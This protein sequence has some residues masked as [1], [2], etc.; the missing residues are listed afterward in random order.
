MIKLSKEI[1]EFLKESNHIEKEYSN[2]A[3][4]DSKKAWKFAYDNKNKI[5]LD[6]ILEIHR[7]LMERIRSDIAGKLRTCDVMI[8][9]KRKRFVSN[10]IMEVELKD[11]LNNISIPRF[12]PNKE[13]EFAKHCHVMFEEIH[14]FE[15]GN[16]RTGRI[17]Y[18]IQRLNLGLPIHTIHV[19]EEQMEY[20]KWFN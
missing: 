13:E 8:G 9:G 17:L 10:S 4:L 7:L 2:V 1:V 6:Y 19:G 5:T 15:D 20:Y 11:V 18:N 14:P 12:I 16:G 3:L